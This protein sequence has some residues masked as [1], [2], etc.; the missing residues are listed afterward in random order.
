MYFMHIADGCQPLSVWRTPASAA[1]ASAA[2]RAGA[3]RAPQ[4]A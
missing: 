3:P 2:R 1:A 4:A